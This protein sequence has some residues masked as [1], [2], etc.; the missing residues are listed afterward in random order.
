[1]N[2]LAHFALSS[3]DDRERLGSWIPDLF[4]QSVLGSFRDPAIRRGMELHRLVDRVTD[5]HPAMWGARAALPPELR[6]GGGI[7][8]DVVWDHFLSR[9]FPERTGRPLRPFVEEVLAGLERVV[10]VAPPE[11]AA[12]LQRMRQEDWLGSYGTA[13]GVEQTLERISRRLSPRARQVLLPS[14][15][16]DHLRDREEALRQAFDEVWRTVT[17]AV[18]HWR[19]QS[20]D[21][22]SHPGGKGMNDER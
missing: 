21:A 3:E 18:A 13:V 2:W 19:E 5:G 22:L 1:M 10:V 17:Q 8:L 7:V 12:V 15:A 20:Q 14:R 9:E 11:T 6:R 16:A 4:P